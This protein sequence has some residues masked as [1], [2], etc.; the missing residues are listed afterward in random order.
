MA[1]A[2]GPCTR[3]SGGDGARPI[4]ADAGTTGTVAS[5]RRVGAPRGSSLDPV[6][7]RR[8]EAADRVHDLGKQVRLPRVAEIDPGRDVGQSGES[9]GDHSATAMTAR[10]S[11]PGISAHAW[12]VGTQ[13][14][15]MPA[16]AITK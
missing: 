2:R 15:V 4:R 14:S 1:G 12:S 6:L 10:D 16:R 11:T 9:G 7:D 13:T 3:S 8:A 5:G